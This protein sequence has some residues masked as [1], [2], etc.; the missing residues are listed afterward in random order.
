MR[1]NCRFDEREG[2]SLVTFTVLSTS[3]SGTFVLSLL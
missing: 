2:I 1:L 3:L